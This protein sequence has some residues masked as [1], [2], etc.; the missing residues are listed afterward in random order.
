MQTAIS[1]EFQTTPEGQEAEAILRTCVHC[2]FCLA[3]CPT[4]LHRGDEL[5]GP[6]GRI[7]LMTQVLEGEPGFLK[8]IG[9]RTRLRLDMRDDPM[10]REDQFQLLA[11]P[12]ETDVTERYAS[13]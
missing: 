4:Y 12:A 10:L 13:R 3:T 2:G 9:K 7:Y 5:D 8:R 6:R 1:S 11:G